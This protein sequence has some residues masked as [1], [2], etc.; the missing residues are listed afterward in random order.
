MAARGYAGAIAI[1]TTVPAPYDDV[2]NCRA[3][4]RAANPNAGVGEFAEATSRCLAARGH[5]ESEESHQQSSDSIAQ[6]RAKAAAAEA[7]SGDV[8]FDDIYAKCIAETAH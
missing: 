4:A 8:K 7:K 6:C 2:A 1:A 5:G 3:E